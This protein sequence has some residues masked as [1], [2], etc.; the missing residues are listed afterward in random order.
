MRMMYETGQFQ[1]VNGGCCR[2]V[3][4]WGPEREGKEMVC[5]PWVGWYL[6]W[7]EIVEV[8]PMILLLSLDFLLRGTF[9]KGDVKS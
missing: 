1:A 9:G 8:K 5:L 4:G 3:H 2:I 6:A 7:V